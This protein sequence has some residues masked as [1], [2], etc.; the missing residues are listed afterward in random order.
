MR[1]FL[2]TMAVLIGTTNVTFAQDSAKALQGTWK[3][4]R[5]ERNGQAFPPEIV[6]GMTVTVQEGKMI[7]KDSRRT[8]TAAIEIDT[9]K[10]PH[11]ITMRP[12][13]KEASKDPP[14]EGIFAVEGSTLRLCWAKKG[15]PRPTEFLTRPNSDTVY[16][17]LEHETK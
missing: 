16:L 2:F 10:T 17:L 3:V 1:G 13:D 4:V 9:A 11:T 15:K 14:A 12:A 8:E 6:Q 7:V 5:A